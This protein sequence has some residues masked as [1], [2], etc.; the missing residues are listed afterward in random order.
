MLL[1]LLSVN[2]VNYKLGVARIIQDLYIIPLKISQPFLTWIFLA[3]THTDRQTDRKKYRYALYSHD[4]LKR[5]HSNTPR[6]A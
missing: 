5:I 4:V 6:Q 1:L 3:V 2:I